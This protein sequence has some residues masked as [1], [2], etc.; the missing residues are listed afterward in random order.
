MRVFHAV[1]VALAATLVACVSPANTGGGY[2]IPPGA[3]SDATSA[4]DTTQTVGADAWSDWKPSPSSGGSGLDLPTSDEVS[5]PVDPSELFKEAAQ[6]C[7]KD[8]VQYEQQLVQDCPHSPAHATA[9]SLGISWSSQQLQQ[10][11]R[12]VGLDWLPWLATAPSFTPGGGGIGIYACQS[13]PQGTGVRLNAFALQQAV[14]MLDPLMYAFAESA[15]LWDQVRQSYGETLTQDA[16]DQLIQGIGAIFLYAQDGKHGQVVA[17]S[18]VTE[19]L[20]SSTFAWQVYVGA[21]S[22]VLFHE[23]GHANLSHGLIKCA[24]HTGVPELLQK[25]GITLTAEQQKELAVELAAIGRSTEAQADIYSFTMMKSLGFG[26]EG[27]LVFLV[28]MSTVTAVNCKNK[29]VPDEA[30]VQCAMTDF[31]P[32]K[33]S[34]PPLGERAALMQKIFDEGADLTP[35][36]VPA[37]LDRVRAKNCG[38][39]TC[40]PTESALTCPDDCVKRAPH[41][42]DANCGDQGTGC[43]CDEYCAAQGDCCDSTG[44][45]AAGSTCAGST[46][47]L[48]N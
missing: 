6:G 19:R 35:L 12:L 23:I 40:E 43:Y 34:H 39:G 28:G 22:M 36:L 17:W 9:L 20:S 31:D 26:K 27:P 48:C 16:K 42:C 10:D 3:T 46:C 24:L 41:F 25:Q 38:N 1:Q 18:E 32:V 7:A 15:A 8:I 44:T 33:T 2:Y 5:E 45:M 37:K 14:W 21:V 13:D 30:L 47:G 29:G 11:G 4:T